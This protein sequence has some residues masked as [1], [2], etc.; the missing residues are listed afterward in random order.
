MFTNLCHVAKDISTPQFTCVC[1]PT[2]NPGDAWGPLSPG[3]PSGPWTRQ[4][5]SDRHLNEQFRCSLERKISISLTCSPGSP[6]S[7]GSS[8]GPLSPGKPFGPISPCL[9]MPPRTP[10]NKPTK[11]NYDRNWPCKCNQWCCAYGLNYN[12][13]NINWQIWILGTFGPCFPMSPFTPLM[14]DIPCH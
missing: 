5:H 4:R 12:L 11:L 7:P 13:I 10:Y 3:R 2:F 6:L 1:V 14:P 8:L 9:P